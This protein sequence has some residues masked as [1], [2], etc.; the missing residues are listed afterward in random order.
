MSI[1]LQSNIIQPSIVNIRNTLEFQFN[2]LPIWIF[3]IWVYC[4][5]F[6]LYHFH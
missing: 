3:L 1:N 2:Q 4:L 5:A 6:F